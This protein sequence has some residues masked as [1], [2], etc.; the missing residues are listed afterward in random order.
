M[1]A[2]N[3]AMKRSCC[4]SP[5]T[6][7]SWRDSQNTETDDEFQLISAYTTYLMNFNNNNNEKYLF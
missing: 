5:Y 1:I 4:C 3:F 6:G 2:E 7:F